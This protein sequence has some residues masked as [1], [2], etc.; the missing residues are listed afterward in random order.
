M[1]RA[2]DPK[3]KEAKELYLKGVQLSEIAKRLGKPEGTIRRWK[4]DHDWDCERSDKKSERSVKNNE[5]SKKKKRQEKQEVP[6]WVAEPEEESDLS[7]KQRLFCVIYVKCFNATKAYQKAYG[8]GYETAAVNG[9]R[10]LRNAK[11]RDEIKKLKQGRLNQEFLSAEDVVQKYIDIA[12]CDIKDYVDFDENEVRIKKSDE[13]DG[14]LVREV[15]MTK[16][17]PAIKIVDSTKG[18]RWLSEHFKEAEISGN[19]EI[20]IKIS[21]EEA[22]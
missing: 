8:C 12:F 2:P 15:K 11:V 9:S 10:L 16:Y 21:R 17:G 4:H 5:R 20:Q 14:S 1:A 13:V 18:L 7:D 22:E 19:E 6:D 3:V